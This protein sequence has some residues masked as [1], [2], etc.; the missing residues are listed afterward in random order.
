M[1]SM[2]WKSENR[3]FVIAVCA[4][5]FSQVAD[6]GSSLGL[7]ETLQESNPYHRSATGEFLP[8]RTLAVKGIVTV[9][10]FGMAAC[11]YWGLKPIDERLA[12]IAA[13]APFLYLAFDTIGNAVLH[14]FFLR[15]GWYSP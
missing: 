8:L 4:F 1:A 14:N 9:F 6:I 2:S 11:F 13:S 12:R 5:L 7:A 10:L 3:L 15:I